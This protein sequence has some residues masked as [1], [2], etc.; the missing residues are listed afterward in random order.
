MTNHHHLTLGQELK[1]S[2][3]WA[4]GPKT[5]LS[6]PVIL[7]DACVAQGPTVMQVK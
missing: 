2:L 3:R 5:I 6:T 1:K 4:R 7:P